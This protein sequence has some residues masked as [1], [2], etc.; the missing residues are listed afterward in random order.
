MLKRIISTIVLLFQIFTVSAQDLSEL[1]KII[2]SI[3]K[4]SIGEI[5]TKC[6]DLDNDGDKDYL[7]IY[8][9]GESNCFEIYLTIDKKLERVIQELGNISYDFKDSVDFKTSYLELKSELNHCCGESPFDSYRKFVF[10][11]D[12]YEIIENYV[13][14]DYENYC[15]D[16]KIWYYTF[17][18]SNFSS[19]YYSVKIT[20]NINNIRFSAD[21][22][23][24]KADFVCIESSNVIGQLKKNA[25]VNVLAEKKGKDEDLRTWLYVEIDESD[26]N[27][28]T[29]NSPLTY[30]FKEQKLRGWISNK[31]TMRQ[32]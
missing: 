16:D 14:Y 9:C 15:V 8:R 5:S 6:I 28:E 27:K 30:E 13:R 26:L 20:E 3:K 11:N 21:L 22:E 31:Y 10:K 23:K 18:P 4:K 25:I 2:D 29:C 24:H 17:L 12:S 32:K 1:N 19:N 7:F